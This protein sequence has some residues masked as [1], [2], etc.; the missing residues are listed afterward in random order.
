MADARNERCP[1]ELFKGFK[2]ARK[3]IKGKSEGVF[4]GTFIFHKKAGVVEGNLRWGGR[5]P[6]RAPAREFIEN[7][8]MRLGA[9][10]CPGSKWLREP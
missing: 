9:V 4:T 10:G 8:G 7:P 1:L 3:K 2:N 6:A 5:M